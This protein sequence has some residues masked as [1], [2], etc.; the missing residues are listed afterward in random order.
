MLPTGTKSH[1]ALA[2]GRCTEG[3]KP[4]PSSRT[5]GPNKQLHRNVNSPLRRL[6]P[7]GDLR[8][9]AHMRTSRVS[10]GN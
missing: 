7:P 1:Q 9:W 10:T 5:F 6:S 8:R 4:A 3:E 2:D